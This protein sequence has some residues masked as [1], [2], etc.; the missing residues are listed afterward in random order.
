MSNSLKLNNINLKLQYGILTSENYK[1]KNEQIQRNFEPAKNRFRISSSKCAKEIAEL[2]LQSAI[3]RRGQDVI[4]QFLLMLT[5]HV[6]YHRDKKTGLVNNTKT[7]PFYGACILINFTSSWE[8]N[9]YASGNINK[10]IFLKMIVKELGESD[11]NLN[12]IISN[13]LR[14]TKKSFAKKLEDKFLKKIFAQLTM[15]MSVIYHNK[16]QLKEDYKNLTNI[17]KNI[18]L[19]KITVDTWE[20]LNNVNIIKLRETLEKFLQ[21]WDKASESKLFSKFKQQLKQKMKGYHKQN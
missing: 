3:E 18:D 5:H 9:I 16:K 13:P 6:I 10:E 4:K 14:E 2:K 8:Q 7:D 19:E 15:K 20:R 17:I 12:T 21:E 11:D 1:E